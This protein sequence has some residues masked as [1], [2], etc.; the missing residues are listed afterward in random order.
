MKAIKSF[1]DSF[2][3]GT[4]LTDCPHS[5]VPGSLKASNMTW[6][7]LIAQELELDYKC[8]A[9]PGVGNNY[10]AQQAVT[11]ADQDS[12]NVIV[13]TWIDRWEFF[14]I[15]DVKWTT[16]RPTGSEDH[17][18]ADIYYRHLQSELQDKWQSLNYI[19]STHEYL[20]RNNIPFVSHI[21]D[22]LLLDITHHC[23]DYIAKLQCDIRNDILRFPSYC[24][25]LSWAE[26]NDFPISEA[27]HPLEEAHKA[28]ANI[29][30]ETYKQLV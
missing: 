10:I 8:H 25:F 27:M 16:V 14:D 4:D 22:E 7:A 13:W 11:H 9:L 28:A 21:M 3:F 2:V 24:T 17:P 18:L 1:G 26:I 6:P 12:L 29:W 15:T 19:Y 20:R 23:P 30:L 5:T